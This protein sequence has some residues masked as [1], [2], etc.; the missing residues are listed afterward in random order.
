M[1]SKKLIAALL[2]LLLEEDEPKA[3][4]EPAPR[5]TAK[6]A[7]KAAP[8]ATAKVA[9]KAT[10]RSM[11]AHVA[12]D[13]APVA[14]KVHEAFPMA[15]GELEFDSVG[16]VRIAAGIKSCLVVNAGDHFD[17]IHQFGNYQMKIWTYGP[18]DVTFPWPG[19]LKTFGD[20]PRWQSVAIDAR[21]SGLQEI[22]DNTKESDFLS[23]YL[24]EEGDTNK[25]RINW[26]R[27]TK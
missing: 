15:E 1:D 18:V 4:H 10:L 13:P 27:L 11:S 6:A 14:T 20:S 3:A 21:E 22:P 16:N 26:R 2:A 24:E 25:F 7:P 9:P 19:F 12:A 8:R 17:R 5:T 23:Q